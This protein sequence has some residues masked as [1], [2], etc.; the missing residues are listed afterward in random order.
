M[1]S[2]EVTTGAQ[3]RPAWHHG[4]LAAGSCWLVSFLGGM[5]SRAS[6]PTWY[7]GLAK[8]WFNPPNLVFPIVW[9]ALFIM[10]GYAAYRI[11]RVSPGTAGRSHAL[12]LFAIQ[13]GL[14]LGWSCVFF[15]LGSPLGGLVVIV[16]FFIVIVLM[17]KAYRPLDRLAANLMVPYAAWV[18]FAGVLNSAIWWLNR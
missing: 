13:L 16:P 14:N 8:P 5:V 15:G 12:V 9:T 1:T 7:A 10:I 6:I 3:A 11:M 2:A 17:I 18:A 4:V